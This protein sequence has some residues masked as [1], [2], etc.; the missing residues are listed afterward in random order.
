MGKTAFSGP[1]YG[2]KSLLFSVSRDNVLITSSGTLTE[3]KVVIPSYEDWYLTEFRAYR[4][5]SGSTA[6]TYTFQLDDDSTV[7]ANVATTSSEAGVAL[8]TSPTPTAGEYEGVQMAAG[9]TLSF[10]WNT[11][12]ST[13]APCSNV[14]MSAYGYIRFKSS[15]RSE[16]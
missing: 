1:V 8:S 4:G 12:T 10:Q 5:S 14:I 9:S 13:T 6:A 11:G 2:A 15:T 16:G 3:A 7:V